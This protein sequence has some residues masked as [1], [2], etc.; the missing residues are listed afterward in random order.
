M[1]SLSRAPIPL[2]SAVISF[3]ALAF[4][5]YQGYLQ[6]QFVKLSF[7]PSMMIGFYYNDEGTGYMFGDSGIGPATLKTFEV[8]VDGKLQPTWLEMCRA[9]EFATPPHFDFVVPRPEIVYKPNSFEKLF[10]IRS[11][12]DSEQFKLKVGR[13]PVTACYCSVFGDCWRVDSHGAPP[14]AVGSCPT[15]ALAFEAPPT[16]VR[17]P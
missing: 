6:R 10:W 17:M 1:R 3:C 9:L 12:P 13:V 4:T 14:R 15:P 11:G 16:P 7:Q 5:V 8:L 2:A